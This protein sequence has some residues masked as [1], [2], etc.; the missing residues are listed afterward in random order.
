MTDEKQQLIDKFYDKIVA[1]RPDWN[2]IIEV[3]K[4]SVK[5]FGEALQNVRKARGINGETMGESLSL[6]KQAISK[7]EKG[8]YKFIPVDKLDLISNTYA[9]SVAY[10][11]GLT[12]NQS[13]FLE[14][15]EYFFW[16]FP[17]SEYVAIKDEVTPKRLLYAMMT[18]GMPVDKMME[19][20]DENLRNDYEL[21]QA[22]YNILKTEKVRHKQY[23]N[24]I[25][26]IGKIL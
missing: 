26:A 4:I 16:E 14:K 24:V 11:L 5:T 12:D 13:E 7:M 19:Y 15:E 2:R 21:L 6:S 10:L 8:Q 23:R 1:Y 20:V 3:N 18:W 9:V 22:L 17:E 25:I